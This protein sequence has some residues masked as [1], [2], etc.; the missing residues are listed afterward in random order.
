M[1]TKETRARK[2]NRSR[3]EKAYYATCSGVQID[4]MDIPKVFAAGE[5]AIAEGADDA[6]LAATII[7]FVE[8]IRKN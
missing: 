1:N 4:M 2:L 3:V 6:A 8:T 5:Q 7:A